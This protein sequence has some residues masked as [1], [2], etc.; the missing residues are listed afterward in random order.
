MLD[1]EL[2]KK[3]NLHYGEFENNFEFHWMDN[4]EVRCYGLDTIRY[5][6]TK[7]QYPPSGC[8]YLIEYLMKAE[9]NA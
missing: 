5:I 6:R 4:K 3:C 9:L 1:K 2:C 7:Q 8:K